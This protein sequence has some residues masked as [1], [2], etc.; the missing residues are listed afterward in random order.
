MNYNI[1]DEVEEIIAR[2][3]MNKPH[4]ITDSL[5]SRYS[6]DI[7]TLFTQNHELTE[8][9]YKRYTKAIE[10]Q[11]WKSALQLCLL[12][13]GRPY[14]PF[15]NRQMESEEICDKKESEFAFSARNWKSDVEMA[16]GK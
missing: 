2:H 11:D 5:W 8:Q 12:Y 9:L 10:E 4:D 16:L 1:L 3:E 13:F 14:L 6:N 7:K 15:I